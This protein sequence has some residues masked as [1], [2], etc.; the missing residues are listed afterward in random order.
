[1]RKKIVLQEQSKR[2]AVYAGVRWWIEALDSVTNSKLYSL[3]A[4]IKALLYE[5]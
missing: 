3:E 5:F 1:M 2:S 4:Q